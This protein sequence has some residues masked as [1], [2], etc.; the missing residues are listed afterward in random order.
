M[1]LK[2]GDMAGLKSP[3]GGSTNDTLFRQEGTGKYRATGK[4]EKFWGIWEQ[5][6]IF[7][8]EKRSTRFGIGQ[9]DPASR[10]LILDSE[11]EHPFNEVVMNNVKPLRRTANISGG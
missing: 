8:F 6:V 1:A 4:K 9:P 10:T 3:A 2:H 7:E 11:R 5:Q